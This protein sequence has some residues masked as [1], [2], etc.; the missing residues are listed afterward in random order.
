[1]LVRRCGAIDWQQEATAL[2]ALGISQRPLHNR[3]IRVT[4]PDVTATPMAAVVA[5]GRGNV[6]LGRIRHAGHLRLADGHTRLE[7]GDLVSVIGPEHDVAQMTAT[8]GEATDEHLEADRH[9]F[10]FR[11]VFVS[12]HTLAGRRL[13]DL[14]LPERF[15]AFVTRMRRGDQEL[16]AHGSTTLQLGDRVRVVAR[17]DQM[18]A[19]STFFGDSY[20]ALSE[21]DMLTF[22]LGLALGLL[23][24]M[25]RYPLARRRFDPARHRG[26]SAGGGADPRA[27]A[28]NRAAGMDAALQRQ[29]DAAATRPDFVPRRRRHALGLRVC[30]D[31]ARGRRAADR[32]GRH[33]AQRRYCPGCCC[34]S[35]TGCCGC[36]WAW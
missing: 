8:L 31:V 3:T 6:T 16:V 36:R 23:L 34:G 27:R 32:A 12:D 35:A 4:R 13:R 14:N 21:I 25:V 22:M 24:G 5:G 26:R 20:R 28:A 1:M 2:E 18:H 9:E 7:L 29:P 11:R 15:G 10:D 17:P 30:R 19:V 33:A